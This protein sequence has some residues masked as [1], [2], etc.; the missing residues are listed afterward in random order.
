MSGP[1]SSLP[2]ATSA[3][4]ALTA[5]LLDVDGLSVQFRRRGAP[6][7]KVLDSLSL[8]LQAGESLALVGESGS[9]KSVAALALLGL[10]PPTAHIDAGHLR[11]DG[12]E[13]RG[14]TASQWQALR[15]SSLSMI[16]QNPRRA[17]HPLLPVGRQLEHALQAR[18][19]R[20]AAQ[21]RRDALA[22]LAQV[23]IADAEQRWRALPGELSGGLCQ[24]VMIALALGGKP[25]LLVADE[26]TTGLDVRTQAGVMDLLARLVRERGMALLLI[27]HDLALA[28]S[29]CDRI[30]LLHAGQLLEDAPVLRLLAAPAHPYT[31]HLIAATPRPGVTLAG[32]QAVPGRVPDLD[33]ADLPACRFAERCER[34]LAQR[35]DARPPLALRG[36]DQRVACWNPC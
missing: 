14:A 11:L 4:G 28:T 35:C 7:V 12:Q 25:R 2:T 18:R 15:G 36:D 10:L 22:L 1:A 16:F 21:A 23:G 27:T 13:L 32:L 29:R 20:P 34:R 30:A 24:R 6:P 17:L 31:R 9:G 8:Q 5:P 19:A 3:S 33:R 26:P